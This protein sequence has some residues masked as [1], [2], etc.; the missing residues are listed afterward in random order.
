ML[1]RANDLYDNLPGGVWEARTLLMTDK[2][3][4]QTQRVGE[5]NR[6]LHYLREWV[7]QQ[8]AIIADP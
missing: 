7:K 2:F 5:C 1:L 8:Q 4:A 6:Q 3:M